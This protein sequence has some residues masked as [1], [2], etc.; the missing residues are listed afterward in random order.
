MNSNS[1]T[2]ILGCIADDV[3]GATDLAIN[4]ASGG[5]RVVQVFGV[6]R[7]EIAFA[8]DEYD[9]VVVALKSRSVEPDQRPRPEV[10]R[11]AHGP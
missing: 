2:P 1:S 5:L 3:T 11:F 10:S 8:P 9:A 7:G 4:L 6:P